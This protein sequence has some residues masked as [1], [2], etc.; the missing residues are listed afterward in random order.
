MAQAF[1]FEGVGCE[2]SLRIHLIHRG[3]DNS[4]PSLSCCRLHLIQKVQGVPVCPVGIVNHKKQRPH[5]SQLFGQT[6]CGNEL[7]RSRVGHIIQADLHINLQ[8]AAKY[9]KYSLQYF[10]ADWI[11][12]HHFTVVKHVPVGNRI[13]NL[14]KRLQRMIFPQ[15]APGSKD[16][17]PVLFLNV[18][19]DFIQQTGFTDAGWTCDMEPPQITGKNIFD[20]AKQFLAFSVP[21]NHRLLTMPGN[22]LFCWPS[23]TR[24]PHCRWTITRFLLQHFPAGVENHIGHGCGQL[25]DCRLD[26][27]CICTLIAGRSHNTNR[28]LP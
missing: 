28:L 14:I 7:V 23:Q 12:A 16:L 26:L 13:A 8:H 19:D 20:P 22:R 10:Y 1:K 25:A 6:R 11:K 3:R 4:Q 15:P 5:L 17:P 21:S 24:Q 18:F 2:C 27:L 9:R